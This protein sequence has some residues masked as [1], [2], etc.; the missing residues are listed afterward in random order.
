M[1]RTKCFQSF[2]PMQPCSAS[3]AAIARSRSGTCHLFGRTRHTPDRP[4]QTGGQNRQPMLGSTAG[5]VAPEGGQIWRHQR[6]PV[7]PQRLTN[8]CLGQPSRLPPGPMRKCAACCA[9]RP[10]VACSARPVPRTLSPAAAGSR[11]RT[12]PDR[13]RGSPNRGDR[14][15]PSQ[16]PPNRAAGRGAWRRHWG[17]SK[18][19]PAARERP[20]KMLAFL[21]NAAAC[22]ACS[23][24]SHTSGPGRPLVRRPPGRWYVLDFAHGRPA[25]PM[26][27]T[28]RPKRPPV[29]G[30]L[31][32]SAEPRHPAGGT[33]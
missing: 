23:A 12:G 8:H 1:L 10:G 15:R 29:S 6:N 5:A 16:P 9:K 33:Q 3:Q 19:S 21:D 32:T 4:T 31:G 2:L 28:D 26:R 11:G 14:L 7:Q 17:A 18:A 22:R 20:L 30:R 25:N 24:N 27:D 13:T